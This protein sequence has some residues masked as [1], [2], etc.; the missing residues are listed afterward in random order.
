LEGGECAFEF[1]WDDQD[2]HGVFG[3]IWHGEFRVG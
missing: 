3:G 2:L 1:I